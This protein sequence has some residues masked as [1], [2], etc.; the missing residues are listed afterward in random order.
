G[1]RRAEVAA[2]GASTVPM[3]PS[4]FIGRESELRSVRELLE[5]PG[6]R[7]ATLTG[8]G[9]IGKTRLALKVAED[10][11]DRFPDG[12]A[13]VPLEDVSRDTLV[14]TAIAQSLGLQESA[15]RSP[16]QNLED[17]LQTREML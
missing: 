6:T 14:M 13:V 4:R 10:I 7:L 8:L 5:R 2:R 1:L 16:R 3:P 11:Q 12:L 9:G 15:N 17:Y